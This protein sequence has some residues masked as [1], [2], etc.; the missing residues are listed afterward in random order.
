VEYIYNNFVKHGV[1][2][3]KSQVRQMNINN[4][5]INVKKNNSKVKNYQQLS[6]KIDHIY[7]PTATRLII[8]AAADR[9]RIHN[10]FGT[11]IERKICDRFKYLVYI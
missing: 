5:I 9:C 2:V 1:I 7:R 10:N 8:G 4:N 3:N 11:A 6:N